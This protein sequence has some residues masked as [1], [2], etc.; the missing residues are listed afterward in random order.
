MVRGEVR[1]NHG[2]DLLESVYRENARR[3]MVLAAALVG[4]SDAEDVVAGVLARVVGR[5]SF[6]AVRNPGGYLTRAVVNEARALH[7]TTSRRRSREARY[8]LVDSRT[9]ATDTSDPQILE[10]LRRLP[11]RQRTVLVLVYWADLSPGAVAAE[12]RISE[13]S[14]HKHLARARATLRRELS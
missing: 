1:L 6:A 5:P 8:A 2:H 4:P 11:V 3:L 12:L 9:A 10:A 13:G 7:R 14:V